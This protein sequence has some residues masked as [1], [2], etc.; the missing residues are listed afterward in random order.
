MPRHILWFIVALAWFALAA[1][2]WFIGGCASEPRALAPRLEEAPDDRADGG[3]VAL[4][5]ELD[6]LRA[7]IDS[8]A[9]TPDATE[10]DAELL[11]AS[12]PD[13]TEPDAELL[14][15]SAPDATEPDAELLDASALDATEPDART[16]PLCASPSPYASI[17]EAST[18]AEVCDWCGPFGCGVTCCDDPRYTGGTFW[19]VCP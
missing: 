8:G 6:P 4:L 9:E 5:D 17:C 16:G 11:D 7:L 3:S 2:P 12:A 10:P 14:D 13:A 15:A 1:L 18:C 19:C